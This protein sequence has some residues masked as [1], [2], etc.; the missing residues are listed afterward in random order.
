MGTAEPATEIIYRN[1]SYR[2]LEASERQ[3]NATFAFR[4]TWCE[5]AHALTTAERACEE[6]NH[7]RNDGVGRSRRA[8]PLPLR[9]ELA[10]VQPPSTTCAEPLCTGRS[11]VCEVHA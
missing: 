9:L 10:L 3:T 6:G 5:L 11:H 8:A 2:E 7:A 4:R 1:D